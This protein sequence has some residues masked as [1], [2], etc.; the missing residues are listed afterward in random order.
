MPRLPTIDT[1]QLSAGASG[2]PT[3]TITP[4]GAAPLAATFADALRPISEAGAKFGE[5]MAEARRSIAVTEA[6]DKAMTGMAEA[7]LA[8]DRD[9]DYASKPQR[10][11]EA[12]REIWDS[13]ISGLDNIAATKFAESFRVLSRTKYESVLLDARKE[14]ISAGRATLANTVDNLIGTAAEA[15]S[16]LERKAALSRIDA[17]IAEAS[18]TGILDAGDAIRFKKATLGKFDQIRVER[19]IRTN[20]SAAL[21][22][23][24]DRN[25]TPY[26][27]ELTRERLKG[28]AQGKLEANGRAHSAELRLAGMEVLQA[29]KNGDIHPGERATLDALKTA[30]PKFAPLTKR[31]AEAIEVRNEVSAFK[32]EPA[33]E[34]GRILSGD[35]KAIADFYGVLGKP[36][37]TV[38][39]GDRGAVRTGLQSEMAKRFRDAY[40]KGQR[41]I[42]QDWLTYGVK[43]GILREETIKPI[44]WNDPAQLETDLKDREAT[45]DAMRQHYGGDPPLLRPTDRTHLARTWA[46]LPAEK[47]LDMLA[48]ARRGLS[49]DAYRR[50]VGEAFRDRPELI[51]AGSTPDRNLAEAL[52]RGADLKAKEGEKGV[53]L[54]PGRDLPDA[55]NRKIG[56]LWQANPEMR[57]IHSASAEA[58]Y[59]EEAARKQDFSRVLDGDRIERSVNALAPTIEFNGGA[60]AVPFK[61]LTQQNL[62]TI[63]TVMDEKA[64]GN[65]AP[66]TRAGQPVTAAMLLSKGRAYTVVPGVYRWTLGENTP[67]IVRDEAGRERP[68][69][70]DLREVLR[71]PRWWAKKE[72]R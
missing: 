52:I 28:A 37:P 29:V 41:E 63:I 33:A 45:A 30:G 59:I 54:P 49:D 6:L 26:L 9:A 60:I 10:Y 21:A 18:G 55:I 67:V 34:Q 19:L 35:Q 72:K 68:Y 65:G 66:I 56:A 16:K 71:G 61:E 14:E 22:L 50:F 58:L 27:D 1:P 64:V 17:L 42:E 36:A 8:L 70:M 48:A 13:S 7:K 51:A 62:R 2:A 31:L 47:K 3:P 20:P 24:T 44:S 69:E 39:A 43:N 25:A 40:E 23:A 4:Q 15:R 5:Q 32:R 53:Y 38:E 11:R 46:T 12:L 57:R